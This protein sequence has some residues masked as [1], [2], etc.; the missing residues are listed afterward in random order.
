[1]KKIALLMILFLMSALA[2]D[3]EITSKNFEAD[4]KKLI[5]IFT[6]D[7]HIKKGKDKIDAQ[8]VIVYFDKKRKPVKYEAI[9]NVK[10][11]IVL[12]NNKTY[13]GKAQK[14]IYLPN[15]KEY[16]FEKDVFIVQMPDQ[17]K[18]YGEKIVV[19]KSSGK[20]KVEG[21]ETKPVK[22]IFKVEENSTKAKK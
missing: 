14:I 3:I 15:S 12:D 17:R 19:N 6:K 18:I 2:E 13:E 10:F 9:K 5:S 1:M 16:I 8:K 11:F 20:A 21:S 22:F 4:E 7:V